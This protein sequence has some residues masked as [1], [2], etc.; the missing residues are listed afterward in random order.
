[1]IE[2]PEA[3]TLSRQLTERFAGK[4]IDRII[5]GAS[6]H[7]FAWYYGDPQSYTDITTG[8]TFHSAKAVGGMVEGTAGDVRLLFSEGINLRYL[9]PGGQLPKKHQFVVFFSDGSALVA[10]VQM[11]GGIGAF[12]AG[13]NDNQYYLI[14]QQKPSPL[15]DEFNKAY[16]QQLISAPGIEKLSAKAFL[17]TEQRIPGLGNGVLQDILFDARINPKRKLG[18]FGDPER[19]KLLRAV[20]EVLR[21]M[22]ER[23]GRDTELDLDG[24]PGGYVTIMSRNTVGKP[25]PSC[26]HAIQ[27][28]AYMGGSVYVCPECQPA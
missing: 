25:C 26:G 24:R 14:S 18:S 13:E 16:F 12:R 6:P 8:K 10:S 1:M 23:G 3:V 4:Q 17:A 15:E 19:E 7:K 20:K 11:Y 28:A 27:K 21:E 5:A 22:T 2:I 9:Q